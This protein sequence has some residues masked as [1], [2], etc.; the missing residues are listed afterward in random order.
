MESLKKEKSLK[1]TLFEEM[2]KIQSLKIEMLEGLLDEKI[3]DD[4]TVI[5][6]IQD[7][8]NE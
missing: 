3:E 1:K 2:Q 8:E 6:T 5:Q 4:E 7:I